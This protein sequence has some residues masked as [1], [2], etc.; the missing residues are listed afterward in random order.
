MYHPPHEFILILV[1]FCLPSHPYAYRLLNQLVC[2][3]L[4]NWE[5]FKSMKMIKKALKVSEVLTC[6]CTILIAIG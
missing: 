2:D 1:A 6:S 5:R 3:G 4:V